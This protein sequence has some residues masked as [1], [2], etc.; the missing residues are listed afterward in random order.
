MAD[1]SGMPSAL[2]VPA[3][4]NALRT[5]GPASWPVGFWLRSVPTLACGD[6][7]PLPADGN[8]LAGGQIGIKCH[9]QCSIDG[10]TDLLALLRD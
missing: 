8:L 6:D 5:A 7:E 4:G 3:R 10:A 1:P 9:I 2:L